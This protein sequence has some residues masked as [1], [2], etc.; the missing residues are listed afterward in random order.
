MN[1]RSQ[2]LHRTQCLRLPAVYTGELIGVEYLLAQQGEQ[3]YSRTKELEEINEGFGGF[4]S[5][6]T[7]VQDHYA[8]SLVLHAH[9]VAIL[10]YRTY[11]A[12][13][14][15]LHPLYNISFPKDPTRRN[16]QSLNSSSADEV[17]FKFASTSGT[18]WRLVVSCT[19]ESHP[20]MGHSWLIRIS[21]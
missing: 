14:P 9:T 7:N 8:A 21:M 17:S 20:C 5:V 1:A 4:Q 12:L 15:V 6:L 2:Q 13:I 11:T 19:S 10:L 3:L 18:M 16:S